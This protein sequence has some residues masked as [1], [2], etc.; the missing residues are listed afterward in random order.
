[1]K[2][3]TS[4]NVSAPLDQQTLQQNAEILPGNAAL[5][6]PKVT[7]SN[8]TSP[9]GTKGDNKICGVIPEEY[10]VHPV[11]LMIQFIFSLWHVL[12]EIGIVFL[13]INH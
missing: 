8:A 9:M 5:N 11:L 4:N 6:S 10:A 13:K 7:E 1:M 12:G 3:S 2:R